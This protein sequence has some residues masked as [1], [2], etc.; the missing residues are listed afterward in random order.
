MKFLKNYLNRFFN[1]RAAISDDVRFGLKNVYVFFSRQG[2]LFLLLLLITFVTGTN[3]GNNL[4]L[5]LFFY[6]LAVWLISSLVTFSQLSKLSVHLNHITIAP[7]GDIAWANITLK[8]HA[9]SAHQIELCFEDA[10]SASL[11]EATLITLNAKKRQTI[12]RIHDSTTIDLPIPTHKRGAMSLPRLVIRCHYPLGVIMSWAYARF[13]SA[14]WVYPK[15]VA[16]DWQ[17]IKNMRAGGEEEQSNYYNKGQSDFDMLDEYVEGESLARVSWSH[18]ARGMG[19]LSKH[20]ADPVGERWHLN[21]HDMPAHHHEDKLS[22]LCYAV[23][24]MRDKNTPFMLSLPDAST[25]LDAGDDFINDC[26]LLLAK[27]P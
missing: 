20:F 19:M 7:V 25:P 24:Q 14:A 26:L 9:S 15:P 8:T 23:L 10:N 16:F 5:G 17:A 12:A 3:Y 4:I 22:E 13:E 6:L 1:Q 27:T 18:V 11:D 2:L 21:Y